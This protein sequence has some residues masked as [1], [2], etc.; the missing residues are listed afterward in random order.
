MRAL[1][2]SE[3]PYPCMERQ[4]LNRPKYIYTSHHQAHCRN[5][6]VGREGHVCDVTVKKLCTFQPSINELTYFAKTSALAAA[7]EYFD[8]CGTRTV[9]LINTEK[10]FSFLFPLPTLLCPDALDARLE[11]LLTLISNFVTL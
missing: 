1:I 8:Q 7:T 11:V 3:V 5:S 2:P 9:G 6:L 4:M 10:P